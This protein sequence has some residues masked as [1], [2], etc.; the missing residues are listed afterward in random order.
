MNGTA[1]PRTPRRDALANKQRLLRA[2]R[3][4]FAERGFDVT[5]NDVAHH[6]GV[7][8]A[9]A[10][11][12]FANKEEVLEAIYTEQI[13]E[14]ALIL[15][16]ALADPDPWHGLVG[17]LESAMA[18]Q[19]KDKGLAQILNGARVSA[20][21]HDYSRDVLAPKVNALAERA[22]SAGAMRPDAT[23]T[24]LI[25]LQVGLNAILNLSRDTHP[26][27]YRRYLQLALDSLRAGA[28][29]PLPV[30]ALTTEQTHSVMGPTALLP[31]TSDA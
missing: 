8:V 30:P 28:A 4:L 29:T 11:R 15:D 14:L 21:Q 25:F 7:G 31:S 10:Y 1:K 23:G 22:R 17:Y 3:E 9:T 19:V 20:E 6:A 27:L 5:L 18:L 26:D 2:A 16:A 24:D 13:R 12:R